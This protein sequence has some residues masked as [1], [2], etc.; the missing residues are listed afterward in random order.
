[1][2]F[3]TWGDKGR[4]QP[5]LFQTTLIAMAES[6]EYYVDAHSKTYP[7]LYRR[8]EE[9]PVR[10]LDVDIQ[11]THDDRTNESTT[12]GASLRSAEEKISS[13]VKRH[14]TIIRRDSGGRPQFEDGDK[15]LLDHGDEQVLFQVEG[16]SVDYKDRNPDLSPSLVDKRVN[17]AI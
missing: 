11:D 8:G 14:L 10:G 6:V 17:D 12:P 3:N 16:D 13:K 1:M 15:I 5:I 9:T 7:E 2:P 4:R